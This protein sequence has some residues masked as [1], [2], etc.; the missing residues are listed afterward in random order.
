MLYVKET[1]YDK[2]HYVKELLK[3]SFERKLLLKK[4]SLKK[5]DSFKVPLWINTK[6]KHTSK[7][8]TKPFPGPANTD[9]GHQKTIGRGALMP[10]HWVLT[11]F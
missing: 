11:Q 5:G 8:Q 1:H 10:I 9:P 7:T 2:E 6:N 3:G 4:G